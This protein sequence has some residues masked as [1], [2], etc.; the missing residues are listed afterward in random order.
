MLILI[1][2]WDVMIRTENR[3]HGFFRAKLCSSGITLW[4]RVRELRGLRGL[5]ARSMGTAGAKGK[6]AN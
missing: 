3:I 5:R 4:L 6:H 1:S 2:I